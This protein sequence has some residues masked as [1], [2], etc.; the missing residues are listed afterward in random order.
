MKILDAGFIRGVMGPAGRGTEE[1]PEICFIGRSNVGKSSLI[2]GLTG[3]KIARTSSTPGATRAI[4]LYRVMYEFEGNRRS[5]LFSDFP[6][7]GYSKVSRSTYK[8]WQGLIERY[9]LENPWIKR[10][11]WVYDVRRDPDRLDEMLVEW[12]FDQGLQFSLVVTKIDKEGLNFATAKKRVLSRAFGN[13]AVFL[14]SAKEGY[15]RTEILSH[16]ARLVD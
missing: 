14:F 5:V 8:A 3:R 4:N 2:N 7:F 15:G 10:I 9:I 16:I 1:L 6:G 13:E 12:L 11:L